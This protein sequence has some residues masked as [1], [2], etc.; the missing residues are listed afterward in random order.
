MKVPD[1]RRNLFPDTWTADGEGALP[2]L[3]PCP[4]DNS[5]VGCRGKEM[6]TSRFFWSTQGQIE[7]QYKTKHTYI[8]CTY[9][10]KNRQWYKLKN[11]RLYS[12]MFWPSSMVKSYKMTIKV[13]FDNVQFQFEELYF[14]LS[15]D[16][17][18]KKC[19]SVIFSY[20][21]LISWVLFVS[22]VYM[23]NKVI[24]NQILRHV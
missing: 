4:H 5:C 19:S 13:F 20:S 24:Q 2:E 6:A 21:I 18:W 14:W 9:I 17:A 22:V 8:H 11:D 1:V 3:G 7:A 12:C 16:K 23:V 10:E 15:F